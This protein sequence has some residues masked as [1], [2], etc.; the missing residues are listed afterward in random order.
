MNKFKITTE[1]EK[2][3]EGIFMMREDYKGE[4]GVVF[5]YE[6]VKKVV[7]EKPVKN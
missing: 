3:K 2:T 6:Q 1:I 7:E 4:E 5:L